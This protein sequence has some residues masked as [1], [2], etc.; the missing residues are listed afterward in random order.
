LEFLL[1]RML[2]NNLINL[3]RFD[4]SAQAENILSSASR[5]KKCAQRRAPAIAELKRVIDMIAGDFF[6]GG[7]PG[8]FQPIANS[9]LDEGN[10]YKVL[11]D[12]EAYVDCQWK[13]SLAYIDVEGW[14]RKS[15]LN[16]A[17]MG[18]FSSNRALSVN[19]LKRFAG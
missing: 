10:R 4:E 19:T 7:N 16:V 11:A 6:S 14:S 2:G 12:F 3:Q 9:L 13:A 17:H 18:R 1:G 15:I 5:Q 8:L